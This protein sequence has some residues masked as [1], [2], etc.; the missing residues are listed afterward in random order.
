MRY[1]LQV[2]DTTC[3]HCG[4]TIV[5]ARADAQYHPA[6][7]VAAWRLRQATPLDPEW[8]G[9]VP[10]F[11]TAAAK[12]GGLSKGELAE[13]LLEIAEN[14]DGGEPK[15]GRRYYYLALSHGYINP[16]MSATKEGKKSRDAA[17]ERVTSTLGILRKQGR[18]PWDM[19]LDLT[20]ELTEWRMYGSPR[21][22]RAFMRRSYQEDRWIGQP[23][24]PIMVVEKDTMEP[25]CEPLARRWLM[26]FASSR[27]YGSLTLQH[28]TAA[29]LLRRQQ[30]HPEQELI[31]FYVGDFDPSGLDLER[32]WQEVL[33]DFG[34]SVMWA[35]LALTLQQANDPAFRRLSIAVKPSDSR[36]KEFI[37]QYGPHCW[38]VDIVPVATI[39][40]QLDLAIKV[41]LDQAQW[42]RRAADIERARKLL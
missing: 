36:S 31:I 5:S 39:E 34:V 41:W 24:F 19:V 28:D 29:M 17:S 10:A 20:R 35:R 12:D 42:Q 1:V 38:E 22:A 9:H 33:G 14:E 23:R 2:M 11:S 37:K 6:C 26:P 8:Q 25:S 16:D 40:R 30:Q 32:Q 18:L 21:E 27:G 4:G 3:K 13:K 7:R 15:T